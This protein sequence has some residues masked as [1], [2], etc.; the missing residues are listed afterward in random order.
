[1]WVFLK[2]H[3]LQFKKVGGWFE[4]ETNVEGKIKSQIIYLEVEQCLQRYQERW[5]KNRCTLQSLFS[6]SCELSGSFAKNSR[7]ER[8]PSSCTYRSK[9]IFH[10][11]QKSREFFSQYSNKFK[12]DFLSSPSFSLLVVNFS[13]LLRVIKCYSNKLSRLKRKNI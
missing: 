6:L 8:A 1:M 10:L 12:N 11:L 13:Q 7:S 3:F 2:F 4:K 5:Q 9:V